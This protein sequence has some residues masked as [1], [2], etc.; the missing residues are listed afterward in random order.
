MTSL[1]ARTRSVARRHFEI[2]MSAISFLDSSRSWPS[3]FGSKGGKEQPANGQQS[4]FAA[5]QSQHSFVQRATR[6]Q[7]SQSIV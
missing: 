2:S 4:S 3:A 6:R 5:S 7:P 1:W